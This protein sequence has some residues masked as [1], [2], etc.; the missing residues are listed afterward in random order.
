M[1]KKKCFTFAFCTIFFMVMVKLVFE[2]N[3]SRTELTIW[4]MV[5][6]VLSYILFLYVF[7]INQKVSP[8]LLYCISPI[9]IGV[10]GFLCTFF[11]V[12]HGVEIKIILKWFLNVYTYIFILISILIAYVLHM[13]IFIVRRILCGVL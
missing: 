12:W 8:I 5:N 9:S 13:P 3:L 11:Y 6:L 10:I 2:F 7:F 4:Y 1:N